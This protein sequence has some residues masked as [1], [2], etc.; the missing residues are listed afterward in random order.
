MVKAD[1]GELSVDTECLEVEYI[2]LKVRLS[3]RLAGWN[4]GSRVG[5]GASQP[6]PR[7]SIGS[8]TNDV[9]VQESSGDKRW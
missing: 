6:L 4:C 8:V 1:S 2:E 3:V 7:S 9:S 5:V